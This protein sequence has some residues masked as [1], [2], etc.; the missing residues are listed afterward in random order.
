M[1][2]FW[3]GRPQVRI[4]AR[5]TAHSETKTT[6]KTS[7]GGSGALWC[8]TQIDMNMT[9]ENEKSEPL[10]TVNEVAKIEN[11]SEKTVRRRIK[12]GELPYI[13]LGRLIR[14]RPKDH[15]AYLRSRLN[16]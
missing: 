12:A 10:M 14:V 15:R 13:K 6:V 1:F 2:D 4:S 7:L 5:A 3:P 11:T 9:E 8:G 16:K